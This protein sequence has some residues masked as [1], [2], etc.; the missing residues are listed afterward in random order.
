M[1]RER[2]REGERRP[3]YR[4]CEP[5]IATTGPGQR[6]DTSTNMSATLGAEARAHLPGII[7]ILRKVL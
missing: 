7:T 4:G 5:S 6:S 3:L 2:E 1:R